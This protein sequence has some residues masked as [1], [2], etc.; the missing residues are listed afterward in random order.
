MTWTLEEFKKEI[1]KVT[2]FFSDLQLCEDLVKSCY[3]QLADMTNDQIKFGMDAM[4]KS[5]PETP[6]DKNIIPYI[7]FYGLAWGLGRLKAQRVLH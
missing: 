2:Y 6:P 1:L 5:V 4:F 3:E 7:R